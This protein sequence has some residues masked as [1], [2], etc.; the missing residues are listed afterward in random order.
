M[1]IRSARRPERSGIS[2]R[3]QTSLRANSRPIPRAR[4]EAVAG[5]RDPPG[6]AVR[7]AVDSSI[8]LQPYRCD[9]GKTMGS[10]DWDVAQGFKEEQPTQKSRMSPEKPFERSR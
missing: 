5:K 9:S 4:A 1:P 8:A 7:S 3:H 2:A 6:G 10:T